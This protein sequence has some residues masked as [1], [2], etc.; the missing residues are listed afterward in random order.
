MLHEELKKQLDQQGLSESTPPSSI[1][2]WG[3]LLE[4][5]SKHYE[6]GQ[7]DQ[8]LA[9]KSFQIASEELQAFNAKMFDSARLASL[10][11]VAGGVAHEINNPLAILLFANES[12]EMELAEEN[13]DIKQV[14]KFCQDISREIF[15]I[16][17]IINALTDSARDGSLDAPSLYHLGEVME[18]CLKLYQTK[19]RTN[20]VALDIQNN[21]PE[22]NLA[23]CNKVQI[24]QIFINL[25]NN[26][27]DA[28]I[29]LKDRERWIKIILD[30][31]ESEYVISINDCGDSISPDL[32]AKIFNPFFTTKEVGQGTGL[33]LSLVARLLSNHRGTIELCPDSPSTK[34][35]VR[36]PN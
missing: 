29:P 17:S 7:N 35:I 22:K 11:E 3:L 36:L 18:E 30:Y 28:V 21:I 34:F 10:G 1:T 5:V 23:E 20:D 8:L 13:P 9:K 6:E 12:I 14:N 32:H 24:M 15:R 27:L 4:K 33:G 2:E 25:L 19:T 26:S 31:H 16:K